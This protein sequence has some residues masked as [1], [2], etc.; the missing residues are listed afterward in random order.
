MTYS[1]RPL[2]FTTLQWAADVAGPRM[3]VEEYQ[4]PELL[5]M[6]HFYKGLIDMIQSGTGLVGFK[7][8]TPVGFVG[9]LLLPHFLNP[10]RKVLAEVMWWVDPNFRESRIGLLLL[11][12]FTALA[13]RVADEASLSTLPSTPVKKE[14]L[15][16]M[17]FEWKELGFLYKVK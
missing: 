13:D 7:D 4:R 14:T 12:E 9:S 1:V 3:V 17:G 5:N 8:E 2:D 15:A 10:E 16:K 6:E 11:K